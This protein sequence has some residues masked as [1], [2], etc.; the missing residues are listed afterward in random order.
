MKT[1]KAVSMFIL[2]LVATLAV[3]S[4]VNFLVSV[5]FVEEFLTIQR[6]GVWVF[7]FIFG[8]AGTLIATFEYFD[9]IE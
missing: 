6:S 1:V 9:E 3:G 5:A 8:L 2:G 7:Y 4:L